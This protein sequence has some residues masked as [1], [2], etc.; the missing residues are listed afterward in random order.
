MGSFTK[1]D[2]RE[3]L[4]REVSRIFSCGSVTT[5]PTVGGLSMGHCGSS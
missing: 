2:P 5:Y 3:L 1:P 4:Q